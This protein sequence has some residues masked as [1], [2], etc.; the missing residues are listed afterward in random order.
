MGSDLYHRSQLWFST[1]NNEAYC[2]AG[3]TLTLINVRGIL[4]SSGAV[5]DNLGDN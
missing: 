5:W 4:L 1:T 3:Y 2:L